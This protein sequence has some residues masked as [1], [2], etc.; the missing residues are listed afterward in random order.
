[1]LELRIF[2]I[3]KN[4]VGKKC[5]AARQ[6]DTSIMKTLCNFFTWLQNGLS[7]ERTSGRFQ[8]LFLSVVLE[9]FQ[10]DFVM[11]DTERYY[12]LR[13][14]PK[15]EFVLSTFRTFQESLNKI[16]HTLYECNTF[17][18]YFESF[19]MHS[20]LDKGMSSSHYAN[21]NITTVFSGE[22]RISP[23]WVR[24]LFGGRQHTIL[25]NFPK[26]C[27]KLNLDPQGGV[28]PSRSP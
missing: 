7:W 5:F 3:I 11:D 12:F 17:L 6:H 28:H 25:S 21:R 20:L 23:T 16:I 22:S 8:W 4:F 13:R 24:Q 14:S 18:K 26:N 27:M 10:N 19:R 15:V 1:M 9:I 2:T